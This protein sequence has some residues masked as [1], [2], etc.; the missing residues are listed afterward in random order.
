MGKP[1]VGRHG[2]SDETFDA[3]YAEATRLVLE[4]NDL[5]AALDCLLRIKPESKSALWKWTDFAAA[6]LCSK[7]EYPK[8]LQLLMSY[9]ARYPGDRRALVC[10]QLLRNEAR[11][12]GVK[13]EF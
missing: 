9:R 12:R 8:S 7:G 4:R 5:D 10:I 1:A 6:L 2:A 11:S 13:W 3:G